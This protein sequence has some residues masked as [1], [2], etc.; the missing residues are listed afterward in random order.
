MESGLAQP[1]RDG[2]RRALMEAIVAEYETPLLRY[3]GRMLR[4]ASTAED[5]VQEV[6]VKL[7][8]R[9]ETGDQPAEKTRAWLYRVTHNEVV[10]YIRRESR[11]RDLHDRTGKET[12]FSTDA[13]DSGAAQVERYEQVLEHLKKLDERERQVLLLRLEQGLSYQDISAVT[14][15]TLGNVG[16]ILHHAVRKLTASLQQAGMVS[17]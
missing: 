5:I 11:L 9:M 10:D 13:L 6:F 3:A 15:R 2:D 14:G 12:A 7:F 17:A 8:R 4:D 1:G 16:N